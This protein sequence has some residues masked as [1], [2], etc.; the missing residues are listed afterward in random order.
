[1]KK[2][3]STKKNVARTLKLARETVREL[4]PEQLAVVAAGCNTTSWTTE[5]PLHG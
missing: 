2:I 3:K 4:Q 5:A 1:M